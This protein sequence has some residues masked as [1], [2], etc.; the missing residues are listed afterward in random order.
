M[1]M[2]LNCLSEKMFSFEYMPTLSIFFFAIWLCILCFKLHKFRRSQEL[3]VSNWD[4]LYA[5][6][7]SDFSVFVC[8][9]WTN[10]FVC[11]TQY[12]YQGALQGISGKKRIQMN[13]LKPFAHIIKHVDEK[14]LYI[15][16]FS[17]KLNC[18]SS[19]FHYFFSTNKKFC[20]Q[21][22]RESSLPIYYAQTASIAI[23]ATRY[24][25]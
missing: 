1:Y 13:I 8:Q 17:R 5:M 3:K 14:K 23:R 11:Y 15:S 16:C 12:V 18:L 21:I 22:R 9:H 2:R 20:C 25:I 4:K 10:Y 19:L 24:L 6:S 7:C